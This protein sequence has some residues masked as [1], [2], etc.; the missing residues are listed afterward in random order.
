M[1]TLPETDL[2]VHP[3]CLGSN[4]FGS[5]ADEAESHAVLDAY[6]SH[7]GNFIDTADAY[8]Q[9]VDGHVG[10]ESETII[11]SWLKKINSRAEI[12]I[13][14]KVSKMDTRPGL[15]PANIFAACEESLNRLQT[16]YIDLY[17]SHGDDPDVPMEETLGAYAQ[18]IAQGKVRYIAASNFSP[19]RLRMALEI[20]K[21]HNLP[22]YVAVQEKYNLVDR[23][24]YENDMAQTV[25]E[26]G[27]SN[28][29]YYG[30]ARGFLSGK[31]RPGVTDV[32]SKRAAGAL[33]Y[34]HEK[35]FAV[36]EAMDAMALTHNASMSAIALA[37]LRA[38]STVSTP[39]ASA[40]TAAQLHEIIQ[41]V[42][43]SDDELAALSALTV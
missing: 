41:V 10:G 4:I 42:D 17:Y 2:V 36:L 1:L 6:R 38:Q 22:S 28:I 21:E 27:L 29:P 24:T 7:G 33:E 12:V 11:G 16:D 3:L 8:N 34:A 31:Y 40:R 15:S 23:A 26:F 18:L 25:A 39:I 14:T 5:N 32:D 43:L 30:I 19:D 35:N 37:W 9:W 20:S 13:A